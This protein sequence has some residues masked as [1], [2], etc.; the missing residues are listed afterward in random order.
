MLTFIH[1]KF[2]L[3]CPLLLVVLCNLLIACAS[4]GNSSTPTPTPTPSPSPTPTPAPGSESLNISEF[5]KS[6]I[7][8]GESAT[9]TVSITNLKS[10]ESVVVAI[11]NNNNSIISVTPSY[12]TLSATANA[13]TVKVTGITDGAA[14]FSAT[15]TGMP[16][17]TSESILV[18][19]VAPLG[20]IFGTQ[21]GLVFNNANLIPGTASLAGVDYSQISGIVIDSNNNM[22]AGTGGAIFGGFGAGKVF[23]YNSSLGYWTILSGSG[24][25][26]SLDGSGV[27]AIIMDSNNNLYA[28]TNA[29][30][31]YKY[32]NNVWNLMAWNLNQ[33]IG[34]LALDASNNLYAGTNNGTD[35]GNGVFK[36]VSGAWVSL[37]SPD[38]TGIQSIAINSSGSIYAATAGYINSDDPPPVVISYG[39]V[40]KYNTGTTWTTISAFNDGTADNN[41]V[42]VNSIV[43]N[44]S[45]L[46]A[47]TATGKVYKY[48]TGTSWT[49]LG[50]PDTSSGAQITS[51]MLNGSN[52][53]AGSNND[54]YNGQVYLYDT[55]TTWNSIGALNNGGISSIIISNNKLYTSTT[56]SG[57]SPEG[58]V[59]AY[60]TNAW[61]PIGT[62]ALDGTPV[63]ST[64]ISSSGNLYAGTQNNVFKYL[65]GNQLWIPIGNIYLLDGSG[66]SALT[67]YES[68]IYAG[69]Q[70]GNIFTTTN[71]GNWQQIA[72]NPDYITSDV[73]VNNT[74]V[75]YAS[76]NYNGSDGQTLGQVQKYNRT[77]GAWTTLAG[78]VDGTAIQSITADT[79]GNIYAATA[80]NNGGFVWEYPVA[81]SAWTMLGT[82]TLDGTPVNAVVTDSSLNVY[83]GTSAGNVFK[84]TGYSWLQINTAPLDTLGVSGLTFDH[85][86]NLYATTYGG[87]VW[88]YIN[89]ST[90]WVNTNYGIGVSINITGSTGI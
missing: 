54:N 18:T 66:I 32:I 87:M 13:C 68:N 46:Y 4:G 20:I 60:T 42:S 40:Y 57:G 55:G 1:K 47:G 76:T 15:T 77:T 74:G 10:T 59:Y 19:S 65:A 85:L 38:G 34:A 41:N 16:T 50:T 84:Y 48:E 63:Y 3:L 43:V 29:G 14:S 52:V 28:G 75:L 81:G 80:G 17:A 79:S 31:V 7:L 51:M 33:P 5:S 61:L 25:G 37:G 90:L 2:K 45:N 73:I 89:S 88:E 64:C 69:M 71:G 23:K 6:T 30:N 62:G 12:C 27:N 39:E 9:A 82:G 24:A 78:T 70:S 67:T 83:A 21:N 22:Y 72:S 58:M 26:G 53:Y 49:S 86:G 8:I 35:T 11:S 36:Y 56:N 44:G